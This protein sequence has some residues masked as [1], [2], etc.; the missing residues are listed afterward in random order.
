[1]QKKNETNKL[2]GRKSEGAIL[3]CC[4][5]IHLWCKV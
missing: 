1:L 4:I 3:W 2:G 5:V